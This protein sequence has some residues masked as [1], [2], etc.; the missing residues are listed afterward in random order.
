[1][2]G[3]LVTGANA[4][5]QLFGDASGV[6]IPAVVFA[7]CLFLPVICGPLPPVDEDDFCIAPIVNDSSGVAVMGIVVVGIVPL[8]DPSADDGGEPGLPTIPPVDCADSGAEQ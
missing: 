1:L 5:F 6:G 3:W 2:L 7:L 4:H 8:R